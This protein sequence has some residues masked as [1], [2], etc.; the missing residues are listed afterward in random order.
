L[1][2]KYKISYTLAEGGSLNFDALGFSLSS[3]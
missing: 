3:L 1:F 2:R